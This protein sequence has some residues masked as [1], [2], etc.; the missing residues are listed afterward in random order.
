MGNALSWVVGRIVAEQGAGRVLEG[1]LCA[2][3]DSVPV[4][5]LLQTRRPG[6]LGRASII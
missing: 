6:R 1:H 2:D 5:Q 4:D 3:H